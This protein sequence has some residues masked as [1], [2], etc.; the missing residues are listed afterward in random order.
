MLKPFFYALSEWAKMF[1]YEPKCMRAINRTCFFIAI[2]GWW[3]TCHQ[4]RT[5]YPDMIWD[6]EIQKW[7]QRIDVP[8]F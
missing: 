6:S 8:P 7:V 2:N 4:E 5:H 3:W 1:G